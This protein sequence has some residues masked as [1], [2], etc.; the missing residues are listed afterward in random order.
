MI[1]TTMKLMRR[2]VGMGI[3]FGCIGLLLTMVGILRGEV[4]LQPASIVVALALGGGVWFV[5]AWAVATAARDVETDVA[6][7]EAP[8]GEPTIAPVEQ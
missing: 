1:E 6:A 4:P 7:A 3:L 5:I 2:P 8:V